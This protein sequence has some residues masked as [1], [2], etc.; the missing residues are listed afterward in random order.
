MNIAHVC[1]SYPPMISGASHFVQRLSQRQAA[2]GH[3]ALVL[4]ASDRGPSYRDIVQ[5][6]SVHRLCAYH[7]PFRKGQRFVL[8]PGPVLRAALE[9]FA[10]DVVHL[11]DPLAMGLPG[12]RAARA[13]GVPAVLTLH[14]LPQVLGAYVPR[15][16]GLQPALMAAAWR[17]GRVVAAQCAAMVAP[18]A[19]VAATVYRHT[20]YEACVVPDAVDLDWFTPRAAVAGEAHALRRR[21]GLAADVPVILAVGRLDPDKRMAMI[22]EAM[23][24]VVGMTPAQL[25]IVGDGTVRA[26]LER[27][28]Q[29]LGL[30]AHVRFT[31][32]VSP[33]ADLPGLYRLAAAFA[34]A[35]ETETLGTVVVEAAASGLP[36]VAVRATSLPGLVDHG[37][38]GW[39][40]APRDADEMGR[41]LL[42]L[43][44]RPAE[45][46]AMGLAG[47]EKMARD[48]SVDS[49]VS[50]YERV[51]AA[52]AGEAVLAG[53]R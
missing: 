40:V 41:R 53:T 28:T 27:L 32:F 7:N 47:R 5:G 34:M 12:L 36:L 10:P 18:S 30:A 25:V 11:H 38:T 43:L 46:R 17:F 9:D 49:T 4:A 14:A 31:G 20:G 23:A 22:V 19:D 21:Y 44:C 16:P 50:A 13:L 1:Q 6:V 48:Y 24:R 52:L 42:D 26:A 2:A 3:R 45:A 29:R 37:Q 35:S 8:R 15:W 33:L 39:L 51:Y